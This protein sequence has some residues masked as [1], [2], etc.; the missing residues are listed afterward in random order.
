MA[1]LLLAAANAWAQGELDM[2][3]LVGCQGQVKFDI[4]QAKA[5]NTNA[6]VKWSDIGQDLDQV[7]SALD[8]IDLSTVTNNV[9][10][11]DQKEA[12][13][14]LKQ[15]VSDLKQA[16]QN[17]RQAIHKEIRKHKAEDDITDSVKPRKP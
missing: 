7:K 6:A 14:N 9:F 17:L 8:A 13:K 15:C 10:S 3:R 4:K 11:G 5:A 1:C 12:I 2:K 16:C